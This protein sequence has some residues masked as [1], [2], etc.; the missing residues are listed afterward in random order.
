MKW[1]SFVASFIVVTLLL[2]GVLDVVAGALGQPTIS[3]VIREWGDVDP[4]FSLAS[5]FLLW[6]L[7]VQR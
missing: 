6:H 3:K 5:F 4:L 1:Q 2:A 7:F